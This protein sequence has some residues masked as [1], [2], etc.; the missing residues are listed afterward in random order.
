MAT[1][2]YMGLEIT[3][4]TFIC[5]RRRPITTLASTPDAD[6]RGG[7]LHTLPFREGVPIS[8][9]VRST[10]V[11]FFFLISQMRQYREDNTRK[12]H[13]AGRRARERTIAKMT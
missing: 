9:M 8:R 2:F 12:L 4:I 11:S 6:E 5:D 7:G 13:V 3:T 1:D 10:Q